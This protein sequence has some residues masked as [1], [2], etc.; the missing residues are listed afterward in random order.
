MSQNSTVTSVT[1]GSSNVS[2]LSKSIVSTTVG[3]KKA[4]ISSIVRSEGDW[5]IPLLRTFLKDESDRVQDDAER[6]IDYLGGSIEEE[7]PE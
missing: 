6:A 5:R 2:A 3:E 1:R 4:T 7:E